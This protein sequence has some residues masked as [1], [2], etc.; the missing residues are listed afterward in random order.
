MPALAQDRV[1]ISLSQ[2]AP[3]PLPTIR[4]GHSTALYEGPALLHHK[5]GVADDLQ[6]RARLAD[7]AREGAAQRLHELLAGL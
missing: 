5:V 6:L 3:P 7:H 4:P 2:L 1:L